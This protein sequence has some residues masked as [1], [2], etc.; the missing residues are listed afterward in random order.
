MVGEKHRVQQEFGETSW[1]LHC[2]G[3]IG[4]APA[5]IMFLFLFPLFRCQTFAWKSR[6]FFSAKVGG[7]VLSGE[8]AT[9][10]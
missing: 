8:E 1:D 10:L 5:V 4:N 2:R 7:F 3:K 9:A 6:D